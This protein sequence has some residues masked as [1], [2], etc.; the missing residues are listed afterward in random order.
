MGSDRYDGKPFLRLIECY[1]LEKIGRLSAEHARLL[2]QM[3]PTL[4][5]TFQR[6]GTWLEIVEGALQLGDE[7]EKAVRENWARWSTERGD[8]DP[9]AFARERAAAIVK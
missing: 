3:T 1:A 2:A 9:E 5:K 7:M 8:G 6:E 4:Q